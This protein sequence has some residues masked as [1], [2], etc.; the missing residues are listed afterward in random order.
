M[1]QLSA[2]TAKITIIET[3]ETHN[4]FF[5]DVVEMLSIINTNID[6]AQLAYARR[7]SVSEVQ[8]ADERDAYFAYSFTDTDELYMTVNA[9]RH[10]QTSELT[11]IPQWG[12]MSV[13]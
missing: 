4:V 2:I 6:L 1:N 7:I 11:S 12:N 9:R 3:G 13:H 5:T 8:V 10:T